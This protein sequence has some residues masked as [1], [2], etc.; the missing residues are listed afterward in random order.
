MRREHLGSALT[1]C[2]RVGLQPDAVACIRLT[3]LKI[4]ERPNHN[5]AAWLSPIKRS[6]CLPESC[7]RQTLAL[8]SSKEFL[9]VMK[10]EPTRYC[11]SVA[12]SVLSRKDATLT[13]SAG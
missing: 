7:F 1:P 4:E 12:A 8:K 11:A 13:A 3:S 6:L 9:E 10:Q 5:W 2:T